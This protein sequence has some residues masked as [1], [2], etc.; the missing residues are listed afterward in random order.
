M[1][2]QSH[3]PVTTLTPFV[4]S[5]TSPQVNHF[6][7]SAEMNESLVSRSGPGHKSQPPLPAGG[8]LGD[9]RPEMTWDKQMRAAHDSG[10]YVA[11]SEK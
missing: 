1:I 3:A 8:T 6:R 10:R 5:Q 2:H 7:R 11:R 4:T 9:W